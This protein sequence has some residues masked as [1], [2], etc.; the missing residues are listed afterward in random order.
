MRDIGANIILISPCSCKCLK[1]YIS[2]SHNTFA[3][4]ALCYIAL[5]GTELDSMSPGEL[6]T[7]ISSVTVFYRTSPKHKLIIVNA[8]RAI[9]EVVAMTGDGKTSLGSSYSSSSGIL[10]I[11]AVLF[12]TKY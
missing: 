1:L 4:F 3:I 9:G 11:F 12:E 2:S 5:S 6:S 8:F 7:I 10:C